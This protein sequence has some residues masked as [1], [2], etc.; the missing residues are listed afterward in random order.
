MELEWSGVE[1]G[2]V[3]W[4][5]KSGLRSKVRTEWGGRSLDLHFWSYLVDPKFQ[6]RLG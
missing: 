1:C 5:E 6:S 3:E 4:S 2:G